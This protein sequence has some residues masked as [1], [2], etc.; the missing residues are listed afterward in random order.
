MI[1]DLKAREGWNMMSKK[2]MKI[3]VFIAMVLCI[4]AVST[5]VLADAGFNATSLNGTVSGASGDI[6]ELGNKIIGVLQ[7]VGIVVSV[8]IVIVLGIKYMMGS[9]E[10][11]AEYKKTMMPYLIGAALIFAASAISMMVMNFLQ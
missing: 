5:L 7:A 2:T 9:V 1:I 11:K 3:I 10:E 8:V 4:I 6:Q